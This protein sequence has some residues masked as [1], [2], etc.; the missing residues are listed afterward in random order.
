V[1]YGNQEKKER[2]EDMAVLFERL[3]TTFCPYAGNIFA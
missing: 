1:D 3:D 2:F